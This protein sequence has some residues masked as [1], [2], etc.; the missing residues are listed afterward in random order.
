MIEKIEMFTIKCDN[1]G[2]LFEDEYQCFC[3]WNCENGA[4]DNARES[5]WKK[6]DADT[7]YCPDC[8]SYDDEDN[9]ILKKVGDDAAS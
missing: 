4:W 8:Y 5:D 9:L 6:K 3:A 7:H 2:K 1:C